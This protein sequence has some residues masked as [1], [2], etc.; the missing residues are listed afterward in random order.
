MIAKRNSMQNENG[1]FGGRFFCR[2][3]IRICLQIRQENGV[4]YDCRRFHLLVS[5]SNL[6]PALAESRQQPTEAGAD[7]NQRE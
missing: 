2:A 7:N 6:F 5:K 4:K 1:P 3:Y